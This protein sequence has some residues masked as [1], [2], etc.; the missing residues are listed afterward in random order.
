MQDLKEALRSTNDHFTCNSLIIE[1]SDESD[2]SDLND[3]CDDCCEEDD[4]SSEDFYY[5]RRYWNEIGPEWVSEVWID[6]I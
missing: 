1:E 3:K 6:L 2:L 4:N 5:W